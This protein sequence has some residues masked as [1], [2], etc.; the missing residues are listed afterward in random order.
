MAV[1]SQL[2]GVLNI[3]IKKGDSLI[4][5]LNFTSGGNPYTITSYEFVASVNFNNE[6]IAGITVEETGAAQLT[7]T[8]TDTESIPAVGASW[9][10]TGT[11]GD[12]VRTFLSGNFEAL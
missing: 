9:T 7:I 11:N 12:V 1:M 2:P 8:L 5:V 6:S 10:L 4:R 3:R